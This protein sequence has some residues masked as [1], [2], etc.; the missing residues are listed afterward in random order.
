MRGCEALSVQAAG[1]CQR[2][3]R[4]ERAGHGDGDGDGDEEELKRNTKGIGDR[5]RA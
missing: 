5:R 1:Q 2:E 4:A 3:G